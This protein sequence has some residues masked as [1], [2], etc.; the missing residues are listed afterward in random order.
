MDQQTSFHIGGAPTGTLATPPNIQPAVA[1]QGNQGTPLGQDPHA[2]GQAPPV[3]PL[4]FPSV[5][6]QQPQQPA[7]TPPPQGPPQFS[8]PQA[9]PQDPQQQY[10]QPQQPYQFNDNLALAG[11][12]GQSAPFAGQTFLP[13]QQQ[14]PQVPQYQPQQ[15]QQ[16]QVPAPTTTVR[17]SLAARGMPVSQYASDD[18]LIEDLG[19]ISSENQRLQQL[20]QVGQ[21]AINGGNGLAGDGAGQ[22][23]AAGQQPAAQQQEDD[24]WQ[25]EWGALIERDPSSG[26]YRPK[27]GNEIIATDIAR[28]ANRREAR[29]QERADRLLE[30]P[31][32]YL[33]E[34]GLSDRLMER[35]RDDF[36]TRQ[37]DQEA[38][39]EVD[40]FYTENGN[41][42]YQADQNGQPIRG[43]DGRPILSQV[44][45]QVAQRR[46]ELT[47]WF[48]NS[49]GPD[50]E[51]DEALI[52]QYVR[53]IVEAAKSQQ[54]PPQQQQIPQQHQ[55][56]GQSMQP[57]QVMVPQQAP[58]NTIANAINAMPPGTMYQSQP[59]GTVNSAAQNQLLPQNSGATLGQMFQQ[60]AIARGI[61]H[62]QAW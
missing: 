42:L 15:P 58:A 34:N 59:A 11:P 20:A 2:R 24:R 45:Q 55:F 9:L 21:Q 44:G 4:Q 17:D 8:G 62:P 5:D 43:L 30:D 52:V 28:V 53:P 49:Y 16:Q 26:L 47:G 61:T 50:F 32:G 23:S 29:R 3:P 56:F 27:P 12:V 19:R 36:E 22:R 7:V 18:Q 13:Q 54:V 25:P 35:I 33:E 51:P 10:Y 14:P 31:I 57:Q 37:R 46:Q 6:N 48:R 60:E 40:Q 39:R 38:Q 1:N 41:L